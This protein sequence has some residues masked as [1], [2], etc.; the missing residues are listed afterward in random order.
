MANPVAFNSGSNVAGSLKRANVSLGLSTQDYGSNPGGLTWYSGVDYDGYI[1]YS[2]T[3]SQGSSTLGNAKPTAWGTSDTSQAGLLSLINRLPEREN[4][5]P[6]ATYANAISWITSSTK[7]VIVNKS[8]SDFYTDGLV[9]FIDAELMSSYPQVG[10]TFYDISGSNKNGTITNSPSY[11]SNG[12]FDFDGVDDYISIS[13][14]LGQSNLS[15]EWTVIAWVNVANKTFSTLLGGLNN[16]LH[17]AYSQ[18]DYR[19]LLYLN[20]GVND[21]YTY[22]TAGSFASQGWIMTTFRFNNANGNRQILKNLTIVG[23]AG[24]PNNT[25]T[26]IGQSSTFTIGSGFGYM[27]ASLSR[28]MMYNRYLNDTELSRIFY[29]GN[30][31]TRGVKVFLDADNIVST[32]AGSGSS[33]LDISG[34]GNHAAKY[35]GVALG[36][37]NGVTCF[38]LDVDGKYFSAPTGNITGSITLQA[39]IYPEATELTVGDRGTIMMGGVYLSWNKSNQKISNYWYSKTPEGYF[40][41]TNGSSRSQWHHFCAV[42]SGSDNKFYQYVD[43]IKVNEITVTGIGA[44]VTS[45]NIGRE[46]SSRQFSGGFG[47]IKIHDVALTQSEVLQDFNTYRK[48]FGI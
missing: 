13:N 30:T 27:Q 26:P 25:S 33:W 9:Y 1:I 40:E 29:L 7:Y 17:L 12:W 42:W 15:Q 18:A 47:M 48:R 16:G 36:K 19:P 43:G 14:P 32:N 21:Y 8:L 41:P 31:V 44:S 34:N 5:A 6:F 37:K 45:L 23:N 20:G 39:W 35:G 28:M 10:N 22:A 4:Q 3:Y 46:S 38:V 11:N 2:D 24:G